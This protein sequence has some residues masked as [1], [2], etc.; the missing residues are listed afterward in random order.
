VHCSKRIHTFVMNPLPTVI[1]MTAPLGDQARTPASL[2]GAMANFSTLDT[3]LRRVI[4]SGLPM[5]LVAPEEQV[6][7]AIKLV[8]RRDILI[9]GEAPPTQN[10]GD[11]LV[12][13]LASAVMT[14]S[15]ADGWIVLP[16]DMP[17]LQATTLHELAN[18]L[19]QAPIVFP[20]YRHVRGH[21]VAF[22]AELY[23]ELVRMDSEHSLRRLAARYP[24]AEVEVDD[25]GVLMTL[26]P[27]SALTQLRAQLGGPAL[28]QF[29]QQRSV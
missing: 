17:M 3:T 1:V 10:K 2:G 13:C 29:G 18:K 24:S 19:T 23:S 15:H 4:S 7:E 28:Q 8:P 14:R 21:P 9:S 6:E 20:T 26:Q 12:S 25:P 5:L 16:A 22:A 11:W 27:Q